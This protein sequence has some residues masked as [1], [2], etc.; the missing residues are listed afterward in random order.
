MGTPQFAVA[1]LKLLLEEGFNI[2]AVITAP[3]RPVGRGQKI[4]QSDVKK[5]A[6][7]HGINVLQPISLK[8]PEFIARLKAIN[9][10]LFIVVAF[11][12]LPQA[13]WSLPKLGTFN[14]HASL[15]PMYRGAAPI[16]WAIINGE[17]K[18]GVTTFFIDDKI[19]TGKI[20][21][22]EECK[23]E[24][25]DNAGD[26]HDKLMEMGAKLVV[27]TAEALI[28]GVASAV[29]QQNGAQ[30]KIA[31]KLSK[32]SGAIN[33]ALPCT[34]ILNLI[35]GLSPYPTA[36]TVLK[37]DQK[38][39]PVKIFEAVACKSPSSLTIGEIETDNKNYLRVGCKKGSLKIK[40]LQAA[41]KK[42]LTIK[43]FLAGLRDAQSYHFSS[44]PKNNE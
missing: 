23:I 30:L 43:E 25:S 21:F 22:R 27:K 12:M 14:L 9:A 39:I 18:S 26:L 7:E 15:L 33:W 17:S 1:P 31:P 3:D 29:E 13:V 16:N 4:A 10:H 44:K 2:C 11:R 41:G 28:I 40:S 8:D 32:E 19:D 20:L 24:E 6:A 38:S 34:E 42:R 5:F 36:Y 35:R 37:N